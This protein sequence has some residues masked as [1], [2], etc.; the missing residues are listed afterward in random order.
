VYEAAPDVKILDAIR[1]D[2]FNVELI[3]MVR[4]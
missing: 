4:V 1:G 2:I 3:G